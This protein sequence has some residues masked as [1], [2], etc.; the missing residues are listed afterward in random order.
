[1]DTRDDN[2]TP[3]WTSEDLRDDPHR[4]PDK[5]GRVRRMF[6]AIAGRY[7]LNNRVHSF[8]RDQSWRRKAVRMADVGP[9][10]H[11]L[12][13]ACGTGD[14]TFALARCNPASIQGID[15]SAGMLE[16]ADRKAPRHAGTTATFTRGDAMSLDVPDESCTVVTIAFGIRNVTEPHLALAEFHRVLAPGGRL[17]IL[18]VSQPANPLVRF[19]ADLYNHRIMPLTAT[20]L[21]GDRSGAYRYLPRSIESFASA[22]EL[23]ALVSEQGFESVSQRPLTFG[24]CTLTHGIKPAASH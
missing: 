16:I 4:A 6:D 14:L 17:V 8:G 18:E 9:S 7:D 23:G 3:A 2:A 13:V 5:A 22:E 10:D 20:L 12:D 15:F 11:V 1:M 21:S 24:I 19:G